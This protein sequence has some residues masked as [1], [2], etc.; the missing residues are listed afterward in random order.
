MPTRAGEKEKNP[1]LQPTSQPPTLTELRATSRSAL[2][3]T[4][5]LPFPVRI[6]RRT[7]SGRSEDADVD[8][9]GYGSVPT[10]S[11]SPAAAATAVASR[12]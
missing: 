5:R 12:R 8:V 3:L 11:P 7:F 2:K 9:C 6:K 4:F 10:I 1:P